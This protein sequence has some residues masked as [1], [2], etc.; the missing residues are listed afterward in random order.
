MNIYNIVREKIVNLVS[1]KYKSIDQKTL[2]LI[3]CEQPKN[4]KF[5]DLS[6]NVLMV[7]KKKSSNDL[8]DSKNY[9]INEL[10]NISLFEEVSYIKPGF[11]NF[12]MK[13]KI[14]Y[15]ILCDI[16]ENDNYGI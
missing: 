3:T 16:I 13:K 12:I 1:R 7:L 6:T 2:N 11:I 15:K 4:L 8:N 9:I 10:K 14:W 5:G